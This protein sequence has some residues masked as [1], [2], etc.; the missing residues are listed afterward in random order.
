MLS[1]LVALILGYTW[2]SYVAGRLSL[3]Q[4]TFPTKPWLRLLCG[5]LLTALSML[6][7]YIVLD[8]VNMVMV[9]LHIVGISLLV[10]GCAALCKYIAHRHIKPDYRTA[11][12]LLL[13]VLWLGVGWY[14]AHHVRRTEYNLTTPKHLG[15]KQLKVAGFSDSH[16]GATFHWQEFEAYIDRINAERPDIVVIMGDFVDENTSSE[17][18]ERSCK[19]LRRLQTRYGVF[20]VYGNHDASNWSNES[21][22]ELEEHLEANGVKILSDE[23]YR[24]H[25]NLYICGRLDKIRSGRRFSAATLMAERK[26]EDYVICLDHEPSDYAAE[27]AS[28]MDL[29]IS[30]HTH[31]GQ[32]L[33]L[34]TIGRWMGA[35]DAFYGH[36]R[37][38]QTDFLVS[39]GIS[40]WMI[41]FKT[42]C[43]SEYIVVNIH[44]Q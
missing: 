30:G 35:T 19:A 12:A 9:M 28:Q 13:T 39:S 31:G 26:P 5:A 14:N 17:D 2:L 18:M 23:F 37:R 42:G 22:E 15:V 24:I 7:L 1:V 8:L 41:K 34:G 16:I 44:Q 21:N 33:G 40:D 3:L 38:Q 20:Y 10:E 11:I 36:E 4:R 29:V 43:F 32:F 27:A 25:E 6:L